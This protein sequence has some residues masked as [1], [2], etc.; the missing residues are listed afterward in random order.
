MDNNLFI[1]DGLFNYICERPVLHNEDIIQCL[2]RDLKCISP[3]IVYWSSHRVSWEENHES[4]FLSKR[5]HTCTNDTA[6]SCTFLC[7]GSRVEFVDRPSLF[8]VAV[9]ILQQGQGGTSTSSSSLARWPAA[10]CRLRKNNLLPSKFTS[11][12]S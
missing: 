4:T 8:S 3:C 9:I 11:S 10:L 1:P 12:I 7:P 2:K 5:R 6:A